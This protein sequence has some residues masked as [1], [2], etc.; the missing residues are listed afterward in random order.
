MGMR[1]DIS[2]KN[3]SGN[4]LRNRV[5]QT[6]GYLNQSMILSPV[7]PVQFFAD[8]FTHPAPHD[9]PS[10][11]VSP[12]RIEQYA[13]PLFW[14]IPT[15]QL[16]I[17]VFAPQ[18]IAVNAEVVYAFWQSVDM[19]LLVPFQVFCQLTTH[20]F[21]KYAVSMTASVD[22]FL[23][24]SFHATVGAIEETR[25][26]PKRQLAFAEPKFAMPISAAIAAALPEYG[27]VETCAPTSVHPPPSLTM[28]QYASKAAKGPVP[29]MS[30]E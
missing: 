23:D 22:E 11:L 12:M 30:M 2:S 1:F 3:T 14:P 18:R 20:V 9:V 26:E 29:S 13:P 6:F 25:D 5:C 16:V 10:E 27:A 4:Y 21:L 24:W 28:S 7:P 17:P 15:E 19:E 8:E